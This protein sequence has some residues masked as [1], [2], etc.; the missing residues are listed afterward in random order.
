MC[1][2]HQLEDS[3]QIPFQAKYQQFTRQR[4]TGTTPCFWTMDCNTFNPQNHIKSLQILELWYGLLTITW[5]SLTEDIPGSNLHSTLKWFLY[6]SQK[7][8][9]LHPSN[10][11]QQMPPQVFQRKYTDWLMHDYMLLCSCRGNPQLL[12]MLCNSERSIRFVLY[13][14]S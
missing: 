5:T 7:N 2:Y 4:V 12:S 14:S 3:K 10:N 13:Q 8:L 1:Q 11:M 9:P 6:H